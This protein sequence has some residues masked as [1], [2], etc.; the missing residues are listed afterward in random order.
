MTK[1]LGLSPE[2]VFVEE[3]P[4]PEIK[5]GEGRAAKDKINDAYYDIYEKEGLEST[6]CVNVSS[7]SVGLT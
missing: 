1:K 4:P 6:L 7:K 3:T 2:P 5:P